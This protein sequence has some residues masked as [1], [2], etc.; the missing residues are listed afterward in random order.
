MAKTITID[1]ALVLQVRVTANPNGKIQVYCEHL[2]RFGTTTIQYLNTDVT[3]LLSSSEQANALSF[4]D[5]VVKAI[6]A[7]QGVPASPA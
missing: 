7:D 5:A 2:L 4:L 6:S 1:S 3:Q